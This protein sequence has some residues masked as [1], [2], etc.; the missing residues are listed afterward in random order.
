MTAMQSTLV[1]TA[2]AVETGSTAAT[3]P[4]ALNHTIVN[5]LER[6]Q[7]D[8]L[9]ALRTKSSLGTQREE[10]V[11]TDFLD[12]KDGKLVELVED[13]ENPNR[14]LLAAWVR[15]HRFNTSETSNTNGRVFVPLQ[16]NNEVLRQVRLP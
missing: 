14:T 9:R 5:P 1:V 16:R 13:P 4:S 10:V 2:E 7:P 11:P 3:R 8:E 15:R 12:C 6:N